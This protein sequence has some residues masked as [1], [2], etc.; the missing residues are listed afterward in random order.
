MK[1]RVIRGPMLLMMV[2]IKRKR[3]RRVRIMMKSTTM[4]M[5]VMIKRRRRKLMVIRRRAKWRYDD[6]DNKYDDNE[7][8][9]MNIRF[10]VDSNLVIHGVRA[11]INI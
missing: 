3:R 11:V 1:L 9:E 2:M 7:L 6:G 5:M 4:M 8:S 10:W